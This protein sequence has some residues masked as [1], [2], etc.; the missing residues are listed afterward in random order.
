LLGLKIENRKIGIK[1]KINCQKITKT[2]IKVFWQANLIAFLFRFLANKKDIIK[3]YYNKCK[4]L[5]LAK[6]RLKRISM[7]H[8]SA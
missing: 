6:E 8:L 5:A 7:L 4:Y 3:N 2:P 1:I